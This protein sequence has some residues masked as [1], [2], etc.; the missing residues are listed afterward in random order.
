MSRLIYPPVVATMI[1]YRLRILTEPAAE[2]RYWLRRRWRWTEIHYGIRCRHSIGNEIYFFEPRDI[3]YHVVENILRD[4]LMRY[5]AL[6]YA[7][8]DRLDDTL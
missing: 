1:L 2:R 3:A 4:S 7:A 8:Q 6:R 5:S